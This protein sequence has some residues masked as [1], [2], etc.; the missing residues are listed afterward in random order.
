MA[1]LK[2]LR[3][4]GMVVDIDYAAREILPILWQFSLGPFLNIEQFQSFMKVIKNISTHIEREHSSKI[5]DSPMTIPRPASRPNHDGRTTSGLD[6]RD[7][8]DFEALVKGRKDAATP[9]IL[10][11]TER[12][13]TI[14][15]QQQ[16]GSRASTSSLNSTFTP[17]APMN[18]F[19]NPLQ[20]KPFNNL[21]N[22]SENN[23]SRYQQHSPKSRDIDWS[24]ATKP[25]NSSKSN[26]NWIIPPPPSTSS[27]Y[28]STPTSVLD[29]D[30][31]PLPRKD[32]FPSIAPHTLPKN[33]HTT[34]SQ[35][36]DGFESLI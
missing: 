4:I 2:L 30:P 6:T 31:L 28:N 29:N 24:N 17:L 3:R 26:I 23:P 25:T 33:N 19:N 8:V 10:L 15:Q 14:L 21:T 32:T 36:L 11:D 18:A 12:T 13:D 1:A 35:G 27:I 9:D 7:Q 16:D 5:Q 34:T 20:P 22:N